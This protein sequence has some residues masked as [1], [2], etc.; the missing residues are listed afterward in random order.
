MSGST[1]QL[2][3][4]FRFV[5]PYR[6]RLC[7]LLLLTVL[8]SVLA[9]LM[10]LVIRAI[11]DRVVTQ[12]ERSLLFGLGFCL[13]ALPIVSA[14]C[15][16]V[17]S[18]GIAFVGQR[19]VFDLRI[20]LYD[21]LLS[22]S[23]RFFGKHSAGKLVNRLMGDSG[24]VQQ[25]L[26]GQTITVLSDLV[27]A[28]FAIVATFWLNWRLAVLLVLVVVAFV[29]NYRLNISKI[30]TASRSYWGALDRLS[31]GIQNR[32]VGTVAVK[33]F[34]TEAREQ[35]I[36]REHAE[37]NLEKGVE[38][39]MA[40]NTFW[41][42]TQLIS[43]VGHALIY[44][45]GVAM[46]LKGRVSYG[47]VV[48][49]TTYAMQLLWP[50]VRFSLLAKQLQDVRIA[51]ERLFEIFDETPEIQDAPD[52]VRLARLR[53]KV[54]FE[55][56]SFYYEEGKPVLKGF[57]FHVAPGETV[58]LIGPTGCGK[59]T[60][61]SLLLRFYDVC[62]GRLLLDDTDIRRIC[63]HSLRGQ[64]GIVLQ[65]PLLFKIS[66]ADNIRY[67]K[68]GASRETV[69]AAARAAEIHDFIESLPDG[70]D[71]RVGQEGIEFSVG[72][73][74][75]ITIARA[76]AADPAILI[77]DEATSALD[78]ESELAIQTA[79]NRV[80]QNRTSFIVAHRLSTIRNADRI[81]LLKDGS[82]QEIGN[83]DELMA[84]PH[85]KYRDLYIKHMG[86]GVLEEEA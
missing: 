66:I 58:A 2:R 27:C 67:S 33:S 60:I 21:H 86:K 56:V 72:Q 64:F 35:E 40:S 61:L 49:F 28:T 32:L 9:M 41:M 6:G 81:V 82:I 75:R 84:L 4:V 26:T 10:P 54:D 11:I 31:G 13:V 62:G 73:K 25:M 14:C 18:L 8:L 57:D 34:G 80:L 23:L 1:T 47:D 16:A 43:G 50:A 68:P 69:E 52:A 7:L 24:V 83:H 78:S 15:R 19:F 51:V 71:A 29:L 37:L 77:M 55:D 39:Q 12:G 53:G 22:L 63:Q 38:A 36:Y 30:R 5:Q 74:Q 79:M 44:F 59:S 3:R 20:A 17:Q 70:Y 46:V 65:E 85:G 48:A 45:L 76:I 42:N